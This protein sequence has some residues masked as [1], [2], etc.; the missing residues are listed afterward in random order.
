MQETKANNQYHYQHALGKDGRLVPEKMMQGNWWQ[1]GQLHD[2]AQKGLAAAI[3]RI[4]A[5]SKMK[6][7]PGETPEQVSL[8][9]FTQATSIPEELINLLQTF[10]YAQEIPKIILYNNEINGILSRADAA[11]LLLLNE[12]GLDIIL[13]NPPGHNDLEHFIGKEYFD[14]HMLEDMVFDLSFQDNKKDASIVSGFLNR[15]FNGRD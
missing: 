10:D 3:S 14:H 8:Y 13:Y 15:F 9:L 11:L 4:C 7:Q 12:I 5:N 2:G 6:A 1:Y